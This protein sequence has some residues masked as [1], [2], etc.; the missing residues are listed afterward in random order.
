MK[1]YPADFTWYAFDHTNNASLAVSDP[2]NVITYYNDPYPGLIRDRHIVL[3]GDTISFFGYGVPAFKDFLFAP[4]NNANNKIFTFLL[5]EMVVDYHTAEGVGF[6]F[7]ASYTYT[8]DT[9][10]RLSGYVILIG[11]NNV[12]LYRLDNVDLIA[13]KNETSTSLS[14]VASSVG[15]SGSGWGGTVHCLASK[16][17]PSFS[18]GTYRYLKL[19]ASPTSVSLFQFTDDTYGTVKD[20]IFDNVQLTATYNTFG[21]GPIAAYLPHNCSSLT[22]VAFSNL[23]MAE[24]TSVSFTEKVRSTSWKYPDSLKILVNVDNDGV[25]DFENTN[26]LSTLLYYMM[27]NTAHYVGWGLNNTINLGGYATVEEQASGFIGRNYGRGTFINRSHPGTGTLDEGVDVL[28]AYIAQQLTEYPQIE[29]PALNTSFSGNTVTCSTPDVETSLGNPISAYE[30]R[31]MD[32]AT[33][34]WITLP[35]TEN[36]TSQTF[37]QGVYKYITLRVR[38]SVTG[39]WSEYTESFIATDP[40]AI[41][42]SRFTLD[43]VELMPDTAIPDLRT[44]TAVTA[45]DQSYHPSGSAL[46]DWEWRV[47]NAMLVEQADMAKTYTSADIPPAP[48]FD[49]DG[50]PAGTYTIKLKVKKGTSESAEYMQQVTVYRESSAITITP[51]DGPQDGVGLYS[52]SVNVQFNISSA[53]E[54]ITAYRII[55]VPVTGHPN[56]INDWTKVS[57]QSVNGSGSLSGGSYDVYVQAKDSAG[58]SATQWLARYLLDSDNDG[59][60]DLDEALLGTNPNDPDTDGDGLIDGEELA[61]GTDP[62]DPDTDGDGLTDGEEV[63]LGTDPL[64]PDT[65]GDGLTDGEEAALGTDPLDPDTDGDGLTDGEEVALGTDPLDPDTDGDGLSDGEEVALGTDPL[66]PDT[67]GDGLSDGE[68]VALGTDPLDPDSDGDGLTDGE[69]A[70]LGTD[71]LNPDTDGDGIPDGRDQYPLDPEKSYDIDDIDPDDG[72]THPVDDPSDISRDDLADYERNDNL[73]IDFPDASLQIPLEII[74]MLIGADADA[75][76]EIIVEETGQI[77]RSYLNGILRDKKGMNVI[78]AVDVSMIKK[79]SD[80]TRE[81]IQRIDAPVKI[82]LKLTDVQIQE[83]DGGRQRHDVFHYN[84]QTGAFKGMNA[85][86]DKGTKSMIFY[87]DHFG[88]YVLGVRPPNPGTSDAI[89][90][91]PFIGLF[92]SSALMIACGAFKTKARRKNRP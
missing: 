82:T 60:S 13:F 43:Q 4:N 1:R 66:D 3:S 28:A 31:V 26:D 72:Q 92:A 16:A 38:D 12:F 56:I 74:D 78:G 58:N 79:Y 46:T 86:Y 49:F 65:D 53:S 32:V 50:K 51:I 17:K 52:G 22:N 10:R 30:W 63:A 84:Q 57:A 20:K 75:T 15:S 2:Q 54:S 59:I 71:P 61:L 41:P 36:S 80:G 23:I 5:D 9:N 19:V 48:T 69:E 70:A 33:G 83:M 91:A 87:T 6:L 11:Q 40:D 88:P 77:T 81:Y 73:L 37:P 64:D 42:V 14:G 35:D 29:K 24:D 8:G 25:P 27:T 7:N 55:R 68:E 85:V 21:F 67:D 76:I 90:M 45:L 62:L 47:Y 39:Q 18:S 44:G 89:P 34:S